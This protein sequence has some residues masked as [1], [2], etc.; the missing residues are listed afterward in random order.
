M[1]TITAGH[2]PQPITAIVK[3]EPESVREGKT[4]ALGK[5]YSGNCGIRKPRLTGAAWFDR[6]RGHLFSEPSR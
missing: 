6:L 2:N 3:G 1:P 4:A 5:H